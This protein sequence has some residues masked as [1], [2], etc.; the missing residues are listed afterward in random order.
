M[1]FEIER[2]FLVLTS[3]YRELAKPEVYIQGYV[4]I[5]EDR[6]VRVRI[7][8]ERAFVTFKS[9]VTNTRRNEYE[10]EIP[11]SDARSMLDTMC[12]PNKIEKLR[13]KIYHDGNLWEV[14]E[15]KGTNEGLVVAEIELTS[16]EQEF[17][18]PSWLG[19]EVT[20]DSRYLN[21]YLAIKPYNT[22]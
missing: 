13:Y 11:L 18:K 9:K 21:A 1:A 6:I 16:E 10:Y 19:E 5:Q 2:K 12:L 4:T 20:E 3:E 7:A 8:G 22:W 17:V 14:D 15:F